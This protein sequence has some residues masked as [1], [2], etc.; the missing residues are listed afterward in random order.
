MDP[1]CSLRLAHVYALGRDARLLVDEKEQAPTVIG[2]AKASAR[3]ELASLSALGADAE[4]A[5]VGLDQHVTGFL[6]H[7]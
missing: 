7:G 1:P 4:G 5:S 3:G 6:H 2:K